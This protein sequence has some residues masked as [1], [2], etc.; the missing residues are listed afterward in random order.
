MSLV[1]SLVKDMWVS[2]SRADCSSIFVTVPSERI[3]CNLVH[4]CNGERESVS[5]GSGKGKIRNHEDKKAFVS[6]RIPKAL[7][8]SK[9]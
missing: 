1:Q 9:M 3:I 2:C 5:E 6:H 4:R 7:P 8:S